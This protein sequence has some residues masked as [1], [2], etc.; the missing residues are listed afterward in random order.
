LN[1]AVTAVV[2]EHVDHFKDFAHAE[3]VHIEHFEAIAELLVLTDGELE[4]E[5]G[6]VRAVGWASLVGDRA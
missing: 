6:T 2:A 4:R 5:P 1:V 3:A